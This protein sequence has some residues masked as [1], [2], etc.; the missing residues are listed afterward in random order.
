MDMNIKLK[1][2]LWSLILGLILTTIVFFFILPIIGLAFV[3]CGFGN[4]V[5]ACMQ[6]I[7]IN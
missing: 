1:Y 6:T 5:E 4:N 3:G 7:W 2:W